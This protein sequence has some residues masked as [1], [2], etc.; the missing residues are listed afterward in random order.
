[1]MTD[2]KLASINRVFICGRLTRDPEL[3][4]TPSGAPVGTFAIAS[5]RRFKN[6]SGEWKEEVCYVNVVTWGKLAERAGEALKK[7]SAVYVEGRLR[8][9]SWN[10][11]DGLKKSVIEVVADRVQFLD[12]DKR[13]EDETAPAPDLEAG[14]E[15]PE[16]SDEE[17]PF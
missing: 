13:K 14:K 4:F 1:M 5:N 12:R 6:Q 15:E 7:G 17:L 10:Q 3:R 11:P 9:R 2:V 16:E 8:S